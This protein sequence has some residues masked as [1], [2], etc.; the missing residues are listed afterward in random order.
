MIIKSFTLRIMEIRGSASGH[1]VEGERF[2]MD[3]GLVAWLRSFCLFCYF[4]VHTFIQSHSY[5]TFIR[6]H[7][8]RFLSI[9]P[10]RL[11]AQWENLPGV[12]SRESNS[13]LPYS[14]PT[15]YH[16]SYIAPSVHIKTVWLFYRPQ[17]SMTSPTPP[18]CCTPTGSTTCSDHPSF[19][20]FQVGTVMNIFAAYMRNIM[21]SRVQRFL[22]F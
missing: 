20:A 13:G 12:P 14:K 11:P 7:P 10:H 9:S 15:H 2:L 22:L 17:G 8:P 16:L 1:L 3:K 19:T 21:Y 6:R 5:N 18:S 4:L